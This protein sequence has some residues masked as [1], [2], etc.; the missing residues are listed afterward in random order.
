MGLEM[1]KI[2]STDSV[3]SLASPFRVCIRKV[4][5][6]QFRIRP[7]ISLSKAAPWLT[8]KVGTTTLCIATVGPVGGLVLS[9]RE[10][11][12]IKIEKLVHET[13][14]KHPA[15]LHDVNSERMKLARFV[16]STWQVRLSC[17]SR[18]KYS[19]TLP[20]ATRNL[21]IF[22]EKEKYLVVFPTGGVIEIWPA[23][24]WRDHQR[25]I[26]QVLSSLTESAFEEVE[27]QFD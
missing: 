23:S 10:G 18:T 9:P 2:I 16:A 1:P 27:D 5:I 8:T 3:A 20:E 24:E 22:P 17:E 14:Q 7:P 15:T 4:G 11:E 21:G 26:A 19:L 25:E 6:K 12:I 13:L